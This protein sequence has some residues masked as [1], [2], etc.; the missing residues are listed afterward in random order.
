MK[1]VH[2]ARQ[3]AEGKLSIAAVRLAGRY[4][5]HVKVLEQFKVTA[6]PGVGTLG[7]TVR[8]GELLLLYNPDFVLST[9]APELAGVLLHEVHHVVLGHLTADPTHFDDQW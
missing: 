9:P 1:E 7:V 2:T 3:R 6:M 4:P 8:G 5:F